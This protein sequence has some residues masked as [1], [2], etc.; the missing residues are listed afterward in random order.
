MA[1]NTQL[2]NATVNAQGDALVALLSNGY[3]RIYDGTQPATADTAI[4]SQTLLAELRH[5]TPA[6]GATSN[7]LIT[8]NSFT[9]DSSANNTGTPPWYRDFS[10]NGT[11]VVMDGTAGASGCNMNLTG[12]SAG[13]IIAGGNVAVSSA[14]HDVLNASSGL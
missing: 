3:R 5:G 11:T 4:T 6:A 8:F 10:S 2:A 12:L 14:T 7:G 13:Q 1:L 9:A